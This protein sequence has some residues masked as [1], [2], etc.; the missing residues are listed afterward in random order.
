MASRA[1]AVEGT[2]ELVSELA[3]LIDVLP[4]ISLGVGALFLVSANT[5]ACLDRESEFAT[6]RAIG[7]GRRHVATIVGIESLG[8]P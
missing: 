1:D 2:R 5:L 7:Y 8:R 3:G 6:L 4:A